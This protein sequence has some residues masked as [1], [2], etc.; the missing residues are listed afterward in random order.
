MMNC[1]PATPRQR[2]GPYE[3]W[4]WMHPDGEGRRANLQPNTLLQTTWTGK[5]VG[6]EQRPWWPPRLEDFQVDGQVR[7]GVLAN[8][9]YQFACFHQHLVGVVVE[10]RIDHQLAH[11]S[12]PFVDP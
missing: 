12:F 9:R 3:Q 6:G 4:G 10:R 2:A 5:F 7:L 11:G 1:C 8:R